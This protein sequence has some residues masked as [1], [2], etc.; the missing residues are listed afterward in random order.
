MVTKFMHNYTYR[1]KTRRIF[2]YV[3]DDVLT[4][5]RYE[6]GDLTDDLGIYTY[7]DGEITGAGWLT[8]AQRTAIA[9][10]LGRIAAG[11]V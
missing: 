3:D 11:V 1:G 9:D 8:S 2:V 6:S 4:A 5:H 10:R 7:A